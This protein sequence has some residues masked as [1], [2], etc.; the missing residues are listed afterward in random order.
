[1]PQKTHTVVPKNYLRNRM[2]KRTTIKAITT[3]QSL[4]EP[5]AIKY[6]EVCG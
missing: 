4:C 6:Q 3:D 1:M 5:R 2:K